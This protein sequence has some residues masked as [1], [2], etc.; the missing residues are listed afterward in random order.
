MSH[1]V[2]YGIMDFVYNYIR[3]QKSKLKN[4]IIELFKVKWILFF[5]VFILLSL[6]AY[7]LATDEY[8]ANS[9]LSSGKWARI[10]VKS[11]GIQF[12]SNS[13]LKSMGFS[14]PNKVNVYGTGG[15]KVKEELVSGMPDDL[16][17][18][19][20]VKT[21]RGIL[22]YGV[23]NV[24]WKY[25]ADRI[26]THEISPYC[27]SS[28][29]FLSD[30]SVDGDMEM[31]EVD[32]CENISG[33]MVLE[34]FKCR[35]LH[36]LEQENPF[37]YGRTILGEDFRTTNSRNFNFDMPGKFDSKVDFTVC[38]HAKTVNGNSTLA[39]TVNNDNK[40]ASDAISGINNENFTEIGLFQ[41]SVDLSSEKL[42]LGIKHS[43]SGVIY[44]ARLDYIELFY[45]R[46]F[47]L[48]NGELHFYSFFRGEKVELAGATSDLRLWDVTE[49]HRIKSVKFKIDGNKAV[50]VPESGYR[51][52]IAFDPSV[53]GK[54]VVKAGFVSNQDI[55]GMPSP[56]MVIIAYPQYKKA[57]EKIADLH[58]RVDGMTVHV[59]TPDAVYNEFSGGHP[60]V[61]AFRKML[62]M[63]HD[64]DGKIKFCLLIGRGSYD[65]KMVTPAVRNCGYVPLPIWQSANGLNEEKSFSTDDIIGMLDDVKEE[66]FNISRAKMSV[67]VGR[68]PVVNEREANEAADKIVKYVEN[69]VY[70]AWRNRV[71]L[72]ADD[73]DN[74]IHLDQTE[75][76]YEELRKNAPDYQYEKLYLD[77]YPLESTSVGMA[78]PK[79]KERMFRIWNE[80]VTYTN[81]VGHASKN[82]W[83][84]EKLL[85]WTDMTSVS[86][87]NWS[88]LCA[89]TCS[90]GHWDGD[91]RSGAEVMILN[92][93]AGF[94]A[95]VVPSRTVYIG[96]NGPLNHKISKWLLTD[97]TFGR[98]YSVGEAVMK[99]KNETLDDNKLRYCLI[100]DPALRIPKGEFK[101]EIVSMNEVNVNDSEDMP[102]FT[103]MEKVT[104]KGC[105]RDKSGNLAKDFNGT[106][107]LDL[108]DAEKPI[109]TYGNGDKGVQ[110]IYNDRTT[111]LA[112]VSTLVENGE[113][114]SVLF[115]PAEIENNYSPARLSA[116]AWSKDGK[117][118][119]GSTE[120]FYI[121]GFP[122]TEQKDTIGPEIEY[123]YLNNKE[124]LNE[125]GI[126]SV[127]QNPV[128]HA[129]FYDESGINISDAGIGHKMTVVLDGRTIL[130]DVDSYYTPNPEREGAGVIAYPLSDLSAGEHELVFTV[131]DNL[132][133]SSTRTIS[134]SVSQTK[135]PLIQELTTDVNPAS[136][137]VLFSVL[138]D[139]PNSRMKCKFEVFD[140]MGRRV[141]ESDETQLSDMQG[142]L[143]KRWN[144][145][146]LSGRRVP[147]GIY[148]YRATVETP[149]GRYSSQTKKLAVTAQ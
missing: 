40:L 72:I 2:Q 130:D 63:W 8:A 82:S 106:L 79:A 62:K 128:L 46:N 133:N 105:I 80:G 65:S 131:Y 137:S 142:A 14:D 36:E 89:A 104:L 28:Y 81:Y 58:R 9:V 138:L 119:Q 57:A 108:Y 25:N 83:T 29:Y 26:Y 94:I 45:N 75:T 51:E 42:S 44:N 123:I 16:P 5:Q 77:S 126:V 10:K 103:A 135:D 27:E 145:C 41:K 68:L 32:L 134:F 93:E 78:Y 7:A 141:W 92:P 71:M 88:F 97:D 100:G 76:V 48:T 73:Q 31:P 91:A 15:Q 70:G 6:G 11:T 47:N 20:S 49:P 17:L 125:A 56:E 67:A 85:T 102:E 43:F 22:F 117:E 69:P 61:C 132:T 52:Y 98:V 115:I 54:S 86:N 30:R 53:A 118:G 129:S 13:E 113:W 12:I 33:A 1:S 18:L 147:R 109:E 144:L 59:L 146:D 111:R 19:G 121:Y 114:T 35:M 84:H 55:H 39:Y 124:S 116:Y 149:E 136:V 107:Q 140:L 87:K 139:M 50:F 110:M 64:R 122:N 90:F 24:R 23:D 95:A 112:S 21:S 101:V 143:S 120:R 127:N 96:L 4:I 60:D 74:G 148:L 37:G 3:K 99:G 34:S 38:F 66:D